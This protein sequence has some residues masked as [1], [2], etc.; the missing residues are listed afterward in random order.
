MPRIPPPRHRHHTPRGYRLDV[1]FSVEEE[2]EL[3]RR[4]QAVGLS[5]AA[6]ARQATMGRELRPLPPRVNLDT[7]VELGRWGN[8]FNQLLRRI[9]DG[10]AGRAEPALAPLLLQAMALLHDVR[11]ALTRAT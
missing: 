6:Y 3:R 5:L 4:A 11:M 10:T 1:R 2:A 7:Y 8:N 9:N